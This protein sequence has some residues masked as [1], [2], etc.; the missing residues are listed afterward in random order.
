MTVL[1]LAL[2]IVV[3]GWERLSAI[4]APVCSLRLSDKPMDLKGKQIALKE[5][6][7]CFC[8]CVSVCLCVCLCVCVSVCLSVCV[9]VCLSVCV[10]L[11]VCLCVCLC[12]CVCPCVRVSVCLSVFV[13]VS[14]CVSVCLCV[15]LSVCL[16]VCLSVCLFVCAC[17]YVLL[18][19]NTED[20]LLAYCK[21]L[22]ANLVIGHWSTVGHYVKHFTKNIISSHSS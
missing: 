17:V 7:V 15:R 18:I 22:V 13:C 5:L 4:R 9:S 3:E 6:S 11:W 16:C 14:V 21:N 19:F 10:C 8:V 12:V 2:R 1:I 20:I